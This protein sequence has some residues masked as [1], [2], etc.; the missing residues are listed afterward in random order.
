[1]A[2]MLPGVEYARRRR[3]HLRGTST[4]TTRRSSFSLYTTGHEKHPSSGFTKRSILN[5]ELRDEALGHVA[6]EAKERLDDR[7]QIR[8]HNSVGSMKQSRNEKQGEQHK[9][10]GNVQREVFSSKG[11]KKRFSWSKLRWKSSEQSDCVVCLEEF[12]TG[13]ILVHLPCAHRFH[14]N[15]A[16]PWL[17]TRPRCPCCRM[18]IFAE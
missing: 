11:N 15:C 6:R 7:L 18:T 2:G 17:E 1:M 13:D 5:Q 9:I 3:L 8:R 10:P 4:G 14:W 16:Q 12:V